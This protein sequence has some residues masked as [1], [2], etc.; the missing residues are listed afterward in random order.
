MIMMKKRGIIFLLC[1]ALALGPLAS[2]GNAEEMLAEDRSQDMLI[3]EEPGAT[4]TSV[5]ETSAPETSLPETSA[6]E[7]SPPETSAPETS[8]PETSA[9]ETSA[10]E[11]SAPETSAPETGVPEA[12]TS[13]TG[14]PSPVQP[15]TGTIPPPTGV[16]GTNSSGAGLPGP[17]RPGSGP[18]GADQPLIEEEVSAPDLEEDVTITREKMKQGIRS[19]EKFQVEIKIRN[20]RRDAK[21]TKVRLKLEPEEGI[22]LDAEQ[23]TDSIQVEN[24]G[25]GEEKRVK[26]RLSADQLPEKKSTIKMKTAVSYQC[27]DKNGSRKERAEATLLLPVDQEDGKKFEDTAVGGGAGGYDGGGYG[28]SGYDGG[29]AEQKTIDPMTPNLIVSQYSYGK[30]VM[31]GEEFVLEMEVQN[32]NSKTT[33]EN[34]VMSADTGD[35]FVIA[36]SSNTFYIEQLKPRETVKK[37][38]KLKAMPEGQTANGAVALSFKYEYLK[39]EERAQGSSEVKIAVPIIHPDRF[40]VGEIKTEGEAWVNE[41]ASISLPYVNKG[42]STVYNMEARLETGMDSDENYKFLGN[43]EAGSSGTIDFFVTP[44]EAGKQEL[45]LI[46]TY[47]DAA[48]N[49]K[50]AE[51]QV[52]LQAEENVPEEVEDYYTDQVPNEE[53]AGGGFAMGMIQKGAAAGGAVLLLALLIFF[54]RRRYKKSIQFHGEV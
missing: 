16:P 40:S 47:E 19:G 23:K 14:A 13:E 39:K 41:E 10:P 35:A 15:E 12:S 20:N 7:T 43:V 49:E 36:D 54:K 1:G 45:K 30:E 50:T 9:P 6:P 3:E 52:T 34:I 53:G 18:M 33:V 2:A 27:Q 17:N 8:A 26:V 11:T 37:A 42:K 25:P 4:E 21:M 24:L 32:T 29:A 28:G 51:R 48:G 5:P 22:S 38:L 44:R 31:A 46:V